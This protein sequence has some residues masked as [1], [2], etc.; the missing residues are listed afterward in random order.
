MFKRFLV[1]LT[2]SAPLSTSISSLVLTRAEADAVTGGREA[3]AT[4]VA[5]EL[6]ELAPP[7]PVVTSL[8]ELEAAAE[9]KIAST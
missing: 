3:V 2:S 4:D 8:L 5:A 1:G 7:T 9:A 6:D